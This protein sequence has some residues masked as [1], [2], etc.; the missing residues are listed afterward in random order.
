[1]KVGV[2]GLGYWGPNYVRNLID[3]GHIPVIFDVDLTKIERLKH[4]YEKAVICEDFDRL[5]ADDEVPGIIIATPLETHY[6]LLKKSIASDKH[7]L[8]EKAMCADSVQ[9]VDIIRRTNGKT[10]MVGHITLYC[11]GVLEVKDLVRTGR[12]GDRTMMSFKRTHMGPVYPD[13]D[14]IREVGSH[15]VS[16]ALWMKDEL[17]STVSAY[18]A[19]LLGNGG[20]DYGEV[21]LFWPDGSIANV[22]VSWCCAD[23]KRDFSIIGEK[24][25]VRYSLTGGGE[26][27]LYTDT[28]KYYEQIIENKG[29]VSFK[30]VDNTIEIAVT[31]NEPLKSE[32]EEF[33]KCIS[34]GSIPRVTAENGADVVKVLDAALESARNGGKLIELH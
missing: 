4:T 31:G 1:M 7:I 25:C 17:P 10:F 18:G 23:R 24:G 16:I 14:V 11:A 20:Y 13:V 33:I 12:I 5:L 29:R 30:E 32:V 15:D 8:V 26:Q 19:I 21:N 3:L 6:D 34:T 9:S 27:V 2:V 28:G 22:K